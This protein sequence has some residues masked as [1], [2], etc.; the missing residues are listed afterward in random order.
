MAVI[1]SAW[2]R[3]AQARAKAEEA[4]QKWSWYSL[5]HFRKM[6]P[7]KDSTEVE[8]ILSFARKAGIPEG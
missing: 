6:L 4:S 3:E 8:R 2:G 5:K 1:Y 7:Y